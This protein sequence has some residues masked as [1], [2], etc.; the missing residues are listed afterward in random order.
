MDYLD[1]GLTT[2]GTLLVVQNTRLAAGPQD[3]LPSS[4]RGHIKVR[5]FS[6]VPTGNYNT[7]GK[8]REALLN[9]P[10]TTLDQLFFDTKGVTSW[11]IALKLRERTD[12]R[13]SLANLYHEPATVSVYG[14]VT[15]VSWRSRLFAWQ[16]GLSQLPREVFGKFKRRGPGNCDSRS[17]E[18]IPKTA[19]R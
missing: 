12:G 5:Q 15:R 8:A 19:H 4:E 16:D 6:F 13:I 3:R 17:T 2:R 7:A 9:L 18:P 14:G 1:A 10:W 11:I